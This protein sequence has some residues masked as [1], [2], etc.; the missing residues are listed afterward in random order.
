MSEHLNDQEIAR[1]DKLK[2]FAELGIDPY[3][4]AMW[5]VNATAKDIL[6]AVDKYKE[7]HPGEEIHEVDG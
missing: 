2:G 3:P 1:R 7:A 5:E 4:A 6:E